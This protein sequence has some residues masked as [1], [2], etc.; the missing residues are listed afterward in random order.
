[1]NKLKFNVLGWN[2]P[3]EKS[4]EA[5][6]T[7]C[8]CIWDDFTYRTTYKILASEK[9]LNTKY[10]CEVGY[11]HIIRENQRIGENVL[12]DDLLGKGYLI[13]E[14]P[15]NYISIATDEKLA[16]MLFCFLTPEERAN[17]IKAMHLILDEDY[18]M[19]K[20]KDDKCFNVSVLRNNSY[21]QLVESLSKQ[22][23]LMHSALNG[24]EISMEF[25][26]RFIK[27]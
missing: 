4:D 7:L 2:Q 21:E 27:C 13:S 10:P 16:E 9:L 17:F 15:T 26:K 19:N 8:E 22:Y 20:V 23:K 1:M 6:F 25:L 14:L 5:D 3:F 18:W 24:K 12:Y 11:L